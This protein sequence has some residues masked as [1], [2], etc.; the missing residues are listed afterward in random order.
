VRELTYSQ[1]VGIPTL[2]PDWLLLYLEKNACLSYRVPCAYFGRATKNF[3]INVK[4][5]LPVTRIQAYV[6]I[7]VIIREI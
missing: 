2:V 3:L 7:F 6:L 5:N 4:S 1:Q